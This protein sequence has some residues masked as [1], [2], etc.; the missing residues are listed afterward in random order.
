MDAV[1]EGSDGDNIDQM[2]CDENETLDVAELGRSETNE[3]DGMS[4]ALEVLNEEPLA[5]GNVNLGLFVI[6][7]LPYKGPSCLKVITSVHKLLGLVS[8]ICGEEGCTSKCTID[9]KTCECC[10]IIYGACNQGPQFHWNVQKS[11]VNQKCSKIYKD[12]LHFVAATL[13]SGNSHQKLDLFARFFG[14]HILGR[15]SFHSYQRSLVCP[16]I[17]QFYQLEQVRMLFYDWSFII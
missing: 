1:D 14:L 5:E 13:M 8:E 17:H 12:N 7:L 9:Y 3:T 6:M 2:E 15:S 10:V 11:L 4:N 16:G